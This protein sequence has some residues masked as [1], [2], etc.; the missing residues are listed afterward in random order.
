[1]SVYLPILYVKDDCTIDERIRL[2]TVWNTWDTSIVKQSI[3][4]RK[5]FGENMFKVRPGDIYSPY[6][7]G[8]GK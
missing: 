4:Y 5:L 8:T 2:I 1:M 3:W 6:E 7:Y